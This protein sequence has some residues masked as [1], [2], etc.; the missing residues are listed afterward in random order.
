MGDF[1]FRRLSKKLVRRT[2]YYGTP[3]GPIPTHAHWCPACKSM[4]DFAVEAPFRNGPRWSFDGNAEA[5]TFSPSMNISV[6]PTSSGRVFRCHYFL[7]SG[8]IEFLGDCTH[9]LAGQ[10]VALP[11]IPAERLSVFDEEGFEP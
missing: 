3:E 8:S 11:D 4:H 6:G 2:G 9:E 10:T 7:R 5:P 1:Q